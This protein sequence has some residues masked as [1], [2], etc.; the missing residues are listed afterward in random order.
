VA[1]ASTS[2]AST[3]AAAQDAGTLPQTHDLPSPTDPAFLAHS[4]DLWAAIVADDPSKASAFFFPRAAYLQLKDVPNAEADFQHRLVAFFLLDVHAAHALLGA[5]AAGAQLVGV[6]VPTAAAVW[7]LPGGEQNRIP[8]YRV[9]GTRVTY[10]EGGSIRS[11][12]IFSMLSWRGQWYVIHLG[13]NPRPSNRG[14]VYQPQ[15]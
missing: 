5:G 9:Y 1:P 7:V 2:V 11:F 10:T 6:D 15:G 8:Y 14:M 3:T 4:Q 13:P 12:G